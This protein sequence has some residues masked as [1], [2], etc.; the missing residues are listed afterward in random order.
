MNPLV[1]LV[2]TVG[3]QPTI[4][5]QATNTLAT[6]ATLSGWIDYNNDGVFNNSTERALAIVQ[7]GSTNVLTTLVFPV[8][9][10]GFTGTSYARFRLGTEA[11]VLNSV[12]AATNGEVEDYQ[13]TING[14]SSGTV[15][16]GGATKLADGG[17]NMPTLANTDYL[18][19]RWSR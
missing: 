7:P 13:V 2:L 5:L 11:V 18:A 19:I 6:T 4:T 3:T 16:T 9:P 1:D 15:E 17:T 10:T 14:P 12:G 8:I